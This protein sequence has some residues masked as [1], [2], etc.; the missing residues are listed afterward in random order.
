MG[1]TPSSGM[2]RPNVTTPK[3]KRT[4][5][6]TLT[7]MPIS[8]MSRHQARQRRGQHALG[9]ELVILAYERMVVAFQAGVVIVDPA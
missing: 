2:P 5:Q 8:T 7:R 3:V 6:S 9:E 1:S 4:N